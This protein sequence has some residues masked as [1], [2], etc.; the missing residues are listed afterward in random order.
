MSRSFIECRKCSHKL[1]RRHHSGNLAFEVGI[2]L[3]LLKGGRLQAKCPC[4]EVRVFY[5]ESD[6]KAA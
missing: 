4:G 3:V 2:R 5:A 6:Q 1:A